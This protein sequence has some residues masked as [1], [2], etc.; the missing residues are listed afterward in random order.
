MVSV[1]CLTYNHE[2]FIKQ[3]IDSFLSQKVEF[4]IEILVYNDA[5]TDGTTEIVRDFET[6]YPGIVRQICNESN[7][8]QKY[9]AGP[10]L[11]DHYR[12]ANGKYLAICEGDDYWIDEQKLQK[13]VDFLERNSDYSICF[14]NALVRYDNIDYEEHPFHNRKIGETFM[15]DNIVKG[16]FMNTCSLMYRKCNG[17]FPRFLSSSDGC[18]WLFNIYYATFGKIHY[19]DELMSVYRVHGQGAY[20]NHLNWTLERHFKHRLNLIRIRKYL[21][22]EYGSL[23]SVSKTLEE[24]INF[25]YMEAF[26]IS[27]H[28]YG[29]FSRQT[30]LSLSRFLTNNLRFKNILRIIKVLYTFKKNEY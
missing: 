15:I 2:A 5:S 13:Q 28:L 21:L 12:N 23:S 16:N 10:I 14:H 26:V 20:Q 6:K 1:C 4:E 18:D 24:R 29:I 3:A 7:I 17:E 22:E 19:I 30:Y 11:V 27:T 9:G 25:N 8:Y